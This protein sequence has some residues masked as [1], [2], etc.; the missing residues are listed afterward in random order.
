MSDRPEAGA[1]PA[2]RLGVARQLGYAL[3]DVSLNTG[4]VALALVY[5]GYFL[6]QVA[7]IRGLPFKQTVDV[8]IV[9]DEQAREHMIKRFQQFQ[10]TEDLEWEQKAMALLGVFDEE[11]DVLELSLIHI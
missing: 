11:I 3:G 7:E 2:P 6:P 5:A 4:L 1:A 9:D 10:T 8:A